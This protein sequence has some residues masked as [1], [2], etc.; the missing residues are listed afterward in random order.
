MGRPARGVADRAIMK[1][2]GER[3]RWVREA[4]RL[5]QQE[6]AARI[7]VHQTT[8]SLYER[9]LRFPDQFE[10]QRL[11]AKLKI[12]TQYL[13]QGSLEGVERRLAILLAARHPELAEPTDTEPRKGKALS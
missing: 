7:G 11:A 13:L 5:S 12:S 8:W 9:G 2:V 4:E 6:L 3:L 1:A 10:V